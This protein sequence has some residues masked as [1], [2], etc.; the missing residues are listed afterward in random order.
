MAIE[1]TA[2]VVQVFNKNSLVLELLNSGVVDE[3]I[4]SSLKPDT[5]SPCLWDFES[6]VCQLTMNLIIPNTVLSPDA[7]KLEVTSPDMRPEEH[8]TIISDKCDPVSRLN[9]E[10]IIISFLNSELYEVRQTVLW[11][12]GKISR[13]S[14]NK[15][16]STRSEPASEEEK[17]VGKV[18][19]EGVQLKDTCNGESDMILKGGNVDIVSS[20]KIYQTLLGR[21]EK[22]TN[23]ECLQSL[24]RYSV[25]L[26]ET[27]FRLYFIHVCFK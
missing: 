2:S 12:L 26:I 25:L 22:E 19:S 1:V 15:I 18:V 27:Y 6:T 11:E 8:S 4:N 23:E 24:L 5:H 13:A 16:K 3:V 10:E 9:S 14:E 20:G 7:V 21:L 17:D